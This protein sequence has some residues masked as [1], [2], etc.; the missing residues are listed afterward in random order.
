MT[1]VKILS[2]SCI[3]LNNKNPVLKIASDK[4]CQSFHHKH[5]KETTINTKKKV[6]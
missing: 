5:K 4:I 6:K 1:Q 3:S 2:C